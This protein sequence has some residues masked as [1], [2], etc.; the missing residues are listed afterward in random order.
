[1]PPPPIL[2]YSPRF[3]F[4]AYNAGPVPAASGPARR[5][6]IFLMVLG[7]FV[8]LAAVSMGW[9]A[10]ELPDAELAKILQQS[11]ERQA[12]GPNAE[13]FDA[14]TTSTLRVLLI[15]M[16]GVILAFGVAAI[17]V[18]AAARGG[19]RGWLVATLV[20]DGGIALMLAFAFLLA[21]SVSPA[22]AILQLGIPVAIAAAALRAAIEALRGPPAGGPR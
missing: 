11:R 5:A 15:G 17:G 9:A 2:G 7:T 6:G 4:A 13:V 16:S 22:D 21:L 12:G 10:A 3:A 20:L 8:L 18:G 14:L 1:M 19:A